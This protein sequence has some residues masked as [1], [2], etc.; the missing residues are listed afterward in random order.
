MGWI[1]NVLLRSGAGARGTVATVKS[2]RSLGRFGWL[3]LAFM[4]AFAAGDIETT[5]TPV[6][7]WQRIVSS[8][9]MVAAFNVYGYGYHDR[10]SR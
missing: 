9:L 2:Q 6:I 1:S 4:L 5:G 8:L 3:I 7:S 10:T